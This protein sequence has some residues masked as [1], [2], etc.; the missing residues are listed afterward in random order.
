M[1]RKFLLNASL[2]M[3]GLILVGL[4]ASTLPALTAPQSGQQSQQDTKSV[5]GTVSSIGNNGH[6]FAVEVNQG[7]AKETVQFVVDKDTQVQGQVKVGTS[8][9]VEYVAMADQNVAR[10]ITAQG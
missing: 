9:M 5:V 8:V 3:A 2:A 1:L 4:S 6:S 7:G 10:T